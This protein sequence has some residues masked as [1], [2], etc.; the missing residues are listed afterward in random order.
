M[1]ACGAV[2]WSPGG[3]R[4]RSV[5][6]GLE[7]FQERVTFELDLKGA[8][9]LLQAGERGEKE[10]QAK[11]QGRTRVWRCERVWR[12]EQRRESAPCGSCTGS[13]ET[14]GREA[15]ITHKGP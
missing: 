6:R 2:A 8:M 10:S 14:L 5:C 4:D 15:S 7:R 9:S 12:K 1:L 13:M 3:R 11:A